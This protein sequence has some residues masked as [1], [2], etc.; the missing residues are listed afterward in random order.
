M[1]L[2][3]YRIDNTVIKSKNVVYTFLVY[4]SPEWNKM[5][6]C[7]KSMMV[8]LCCADLVPQDHPYLANHELEFFIKKKGWLTDELMKSHSS[9][10][11][12]ISAK[13][14]GKIEAFLDSLECEVVFNV[15]PT[16]FG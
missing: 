10:I 1:L 16:F 15:S 8:E 7:K 12:E 6:I 13:A 5:A 4:I 11:L 9:F 2:L 3:Q 14:F